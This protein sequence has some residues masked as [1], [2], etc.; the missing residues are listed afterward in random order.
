MTTGRYDGCE[1]SSLGCQTLLVTRRSDVEPDE[2][3]T[4]LTLPEPPST[5]AGTVLE[6]LLLQLL[7]WS[8]APDAACEPTASGTAGTSSWTADEPVAA[9]H[10]NVQLDVL[11][12]SV[13]RLPSQEGTT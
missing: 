11:A 1:L 10:R 13:T 5:L 3:L 12:S 2:A 8:L 6:I 4:V 9:R 7:G